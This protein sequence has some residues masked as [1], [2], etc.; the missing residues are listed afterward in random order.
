MITGILLFYCSE[1]GKRFMGPDIEYAATTFSQPLKCPKCGSWHTRPW[2]PLP[3]KMA[4]VRYKGI[5]DS[6][7]KT[8]HQ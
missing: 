8:Q 1:C 2:S 5:W 6:I 4:N 7:D 3:A